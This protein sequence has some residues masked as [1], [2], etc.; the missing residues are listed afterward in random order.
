MGTDPDFINCVLM[1]E[2]VNVFVKFLYLHF[3]LHATTISTSYI[4]SFEIPLQARHVTA[5]R[6]CVVLVFYR[7]QFEVQLFLR[8]QN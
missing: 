3:I 5:V 8:N 7:V 6:K 4:K 2:R 1:P